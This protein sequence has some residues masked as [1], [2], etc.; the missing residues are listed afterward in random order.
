L[1]VFVRKNN[2]TIGPLTEGE[3]LADWKKGKFVSSDLICTDGKN[4]VSIKDSKIVPSES[5]QKNI[6]RIGLVA[7][8][9]SVL[10][11]LIFFFA[12]VAGV[13]NWLSGSET[14]DLDYFDWSVEESEKFKKGA[15]VL[16]SLLGDVRVSGPEEKDFAEAKKGQVLLPGSKLETGKEGE[17]VILF[18]NGLSTAVGK[19]TKFKIHSF[20]QEDFNSST[21]EIKEIRKEISPSRIKLDLDLGELVVVVKKLDRDSSITLSSKLGFAGVRGTSFSMNAQADS[22]SVNV[23]SGQVDFLNLNKTSKLVNAGKSARS[24]GMNLKLINEIPQADRV[25]IEAMEEKAKAAIREIPIS[26]LKKAFD[27]VNPTLAWCDP[28]RQQRSFLAAGGTKEISEAIERGMEWL[29]LMQQEGGSWGGNDR[30]DQGNPKKTNAS[31]MTGMAVICLLQNCDN[32]SFVRNNSALKKGIEYLKT[33]PVSEVKSAPDSYAHPIYT[34]ALVKAFARLKI[35]ELEELAIKVVSTIVRGQNENGGWAYAYGKGP[36]AHVDLSVTGWNVMALA[37]AQSAGLKVN[38]LDKAIA[39]SIE[40]VKKCQ[41]SL[42]KFAY[43]IGGGGKQ[44]LTGMGVY[45][46][47]MGNYGTSNEANKGLNWL[48][49]NLPSDSKELNFY[50]LRHSSK[51]YFSSTYLGERKYWAVFKEKVIKLLLELQRV[52]GSW[53][54]ANHFHGD[55]EIFRTT[56]ALDTLQTFYGMRY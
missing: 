43:Q 49:E 20:V 16:I 42:G 24:T 28:V 6:F 4:W 11:G 40:Y 56:L 13:S 26:E 50:G 19:N 15:T 17:A 5:R 10:L 21:V 37:E 38:G 48:L 54:P 52:D 32:D 8:C 27:Q 39:R 23:L 30:D 36:R 2:S 35:P 25:R 18:S 41:D 46:L 22:T 9:F 7:F 45:C 14:R 1:K 3:F 51:A 31:A 29:V 55:T 44:S 34:R 33:V 12:D 53:K 47:Q